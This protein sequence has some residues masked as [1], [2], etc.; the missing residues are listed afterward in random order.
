[1]ES[2]GVEYT[3]SKVVLDANDPEA[4]A[5]HVVVAARVEEPAIVTEHGSDEPG[6]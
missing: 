5:D 3:S 6:S 1:M 2:G 4:I